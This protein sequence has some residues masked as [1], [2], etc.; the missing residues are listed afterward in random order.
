MSPQ[1][2]T[3][4]RVLQEV[5]AAYSSMIASCIQ[6]EPEA[7]LTWFRGARAEDVPLS[8]FVYK[9]IIGALVELGRNHT[10]LNLLTEMVLL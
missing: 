6:T 1:K 10:A 4:A 9:Q 2:T 5:E 3:N 8:P 7:A